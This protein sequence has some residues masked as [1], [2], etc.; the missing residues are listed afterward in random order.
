MSDL[1][2]ASLLP[3]STDI[4][5]ELGIA[6]RLVAVTHE[7]NREATREN[8]GFGL[9]GLVIFCA[10]MASSRASVSVV[11]T[12]RCYSVGCHQEPPLKYLP[13]CQYVFCA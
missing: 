12:K 11:E 13:V 4:V 7:V 2:I 1:R 3:S 5:V 9:E 10:A 8:L 6:K